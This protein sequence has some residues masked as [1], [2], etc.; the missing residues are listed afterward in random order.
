MKRFTPVT[1]NVHSADRVKPAASF[2]SFKT[3]FSGALLT[4]K[5]ITTAA[6]LL[7]SLNSCAQQ[8]ITADT[9]YQKVITE[10]SAKIVQTLD[11]ADAVKFKKVQDIIAHQYFQLNAVHDGSK[12]AVTAI[13]AQQLSKEEIN[14]A[15]KKEN[16][17]KAGLLKQL[18]T[19][20]IAL[21]KNDL[22][23]QQV[24]KVKDGMTYRVLPVTWTAYLEMLQNLTPGQKEKMYNWLVEA[25]ELAMDEGS[26]DAKHAVFGKYKG[27][28]NNYLSAAGYD[29]KKEGEDWAKRIQA[30]KE[31]K[32]TQNNL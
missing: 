31:T 29:M 20:F 30:A 6:A 11:I 4:A 28:I 1:T 8:N 13:K 17:K 23:A 27:K 2:F 7:Y 22:A 19:Q 18:H 24:E 26:S 12:A 15:V 10:R 14:E 32:Q 25:R 21:L 16:E 3:F 9:A 5:I